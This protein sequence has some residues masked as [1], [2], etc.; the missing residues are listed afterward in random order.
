MLTKEFH[1]APMM[2]ITYREFRYFCRLLTKEAV[3]WSKSRQSLTQ[4][5]TRHS[6]LT[7]CFTIHP[8]TL[9]S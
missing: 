7:P 4:C 6:F 5:T 8:F 3:L 9:K 2:G 1:V